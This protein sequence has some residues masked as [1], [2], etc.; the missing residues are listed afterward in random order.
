MT[1]LAVR[2][3]RAPALAFLAL[4]G[5]ACAAGPPRTATATAAATAV[6][7]GRVVVLSDEDHAGPGHQRRVYTIR[8]GDR[9]TYVLRGEGGV[10]YEIGGKT[11]KIYTID[12]GNR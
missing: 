8:T 7:D 1:E 5:A 9:G 3:A 10:T 6:D 12:G 4:A 11:V 2:L